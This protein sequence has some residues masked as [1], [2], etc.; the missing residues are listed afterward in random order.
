MAIASTAL[1][2]AQ[3]TLQSFIGSNTLFQSSNKRKFASIKAP[4][5]ISEQH[6]DQYVVTN[7]P[8]EAG[9]QISDHMY[10][11]PQRVD[12]EIAYSQSSQFYMLQSLGAL[13]GIGTKP[14]S[15]ID[16]YH[17]FLA[18]QAFRV[19]FDITTGKRKYKNMVIESIE[20]TTTERTENLLRIRLRCR[21]VIIVNTTT[22]TDSSLQTAAPNTSATQQGG[23]QQPTDAPANAAAPTGANV[24]GGAL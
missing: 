1:G 24:T 4:C 22:S 20:E 15:L 21:E 19:P 6:V 18:I 10:A 11:V 5:T 16:Y 3:T 8:T 23:T 13:A 7:Q 14:D 2:V 17:R 12:I 9:V